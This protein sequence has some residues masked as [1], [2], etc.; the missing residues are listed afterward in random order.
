MPDIN[1]LTS[2]SFESNVTDSVDG[3]YTLMQW[4]GGIGSTLPP[5]WSASRDIKLRQFVHASDHVSGVTNSMIC[6]VCSI[7]FAVIPKDKT[8][9]RHV[10]QAEERTDNLVNASEFYRGWNVLMAKGLFDYYCTDNGL[11][12][13]VL[14]SGPSDGPIIGWPFGL[15]HLDS[16]HCLRT[17]NPEFPVIYTNTVGKRYKIHYTRVIEM[18]SMPSSDVAMNGVGF[19]ATSRMVN[20]AQSL[21][22][23]AVYEQEKMGS[24]PPR[25]LLYGSYISGKQILEAFQAAN[26]QMSQE[27]LTRYARVIA[28]GNPNREMKLDKLD[29]ASVPDGFNKDQSTKLAM[30]VMALAHGVAFREFFPATI[31][32]ATKA[33]AEVQHNDAKDKW[34]EVIQRLQRQLN[35]KFLPPHLE[36]KFD[37]R[38]GEDNQLSA[39]VML[40]E[41]Q[42]AEKNLTDGALTQ[43]IQREVWL[44]KGLITQ[45]QF[46][47][48]ELEAGRLEDGTDILALFLSD[49]PDFKELLKVPISNPLRYEQGDP[50]AA[51][52][53]IDAQIE[54]VARIN[55]NATR[56]SIK[57]RTRQS[58]AALKFLRSKYDEQSQIQKQEEMLDDA[59]NRNEAQ[60]KP[61]QVGPQRGTGTASPRPANGGGPGQ[62]N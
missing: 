15:A 33:D 11:F 29:L 14:G 25:I 56:D 51:K 57:K 18:S 48:M 23:I 27:Q 38:N 37:Y 52:K 21:I 22:D 13:Q 16:A 30:A 59:N 32:G 26:I 7:P 20:V 31:T 12:L 40:T 44:D 49:D 42:A 43:R 60:G 2:K 10:A 34:A 5:W 24:R 47:E 55:I 35:Q 8:I 19:C 45:N 6:K 62:S 9:D 61:V 4:L 58:V 46:E 36:F 54:E 3:A 17:S 39:T 41:A 53:A 50:E 28:V 1:A